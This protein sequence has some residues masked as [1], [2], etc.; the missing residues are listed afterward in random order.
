M[1]IAIFLASL[2]IS[3]LELSEAGAIASIYHGIYKSNVPFLYATLGVITVLIPT[4]ALGKFIYLLPLNYVLIGSAIILFYF[5]YKLLRSAR[6]YFK[7]VK[8]AKGDDEKKE[9]VVVVFTISAVEALEAALVIIALMG[10]DYYAS[11]LGTIIAS[12]IVIVL[13]YTLKSQIARIRLPHMK[14]FLSAL[15][16]SLGTLWFNE[17]F[18]GLSDLFLPLFFLGFLVFN[19]I[20]IKI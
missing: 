3:L 6:R 11:L 7:G 12:I 8:R 20:I 17:V 19:Y 2:G 18:I 14:F 9:G 10:E 16:F 5:G 1:N 13:T 15:L 4:F